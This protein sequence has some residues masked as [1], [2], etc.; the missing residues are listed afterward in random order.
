MP[1]EHRTRVLLS[2]TSCFA[3]LLLACRPLEELLNKLLAQDRAA[4]M[5]NNAS[6]YQTTRRTTE[7]VLGNTRAV[8]RHGED[9]SVLVSVL[10]VLTGSRSPA[11]AHVGRGPDAL[12]QT[13]TANLA[14]QVQSENTTGAL[15]A[16]LAT[17][18]ADQQQALFRA[19]RE[20]DEVLRKLCL[21]VCEQVQQRRD[22]TLAPEAGAQP[23]P[24]LGGNMFDEESMRV[25]L[26]WH[27]KPAQGASAALEAGVQEVLVTLG[28]YS[29]ETCVTLCVVAFELMQG[30]SSSLTALTDFIMRLL[31]DRAD[32]VSAFQTRPGV[33]EWL[34]DK[35]MEA[36][37]DESG[38]S[39]FALLQAHTR[40]S[41]SSAVFATRAADIKQSSSEPVNF[42][43]Y[44]KLAA[45]GLHSM[46]ASKLLT[47]KPPTSSTI[48]KATGGDG[49]GKTPSVVLLVRLPAFVT[50]SRIEVAVCNGAKWQANA[51][52]QKPDK[53]QSL[54]RGALVAIGDSSQNLSRCADLR[55]QAVVGKKT[56]AA[57]GY[58]WLAAAIPPSARPGRVVRIELPCTTP[59]KAGVDAHVCLAA[60]NVYGRDAEQYRSDT[61]SPQNSALGL[62]SHLCRPALAACH[63][64]LVQSVRVLSSAPQTLVTRMIEQFNTADTSDVVRPILMMLAGN[65]PGAAASIMAVL[66][67]LDAGNVSQC[68]QLAVAM[69]LELQ[70]TQDVEAL[71]AAN[72]KTLRSFVLA[73]LRGAKEDAL[74]VKVTPFLYALG[75]VRTAGTVAQDK[76]ERR[77]EL[78]V[79]L[80][81]LLALTLDSNPHDNAMRFFV[82]ARRANSN[83]ETAARRQP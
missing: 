9:A 34:V 47:G 40:S 66:L 21:L 22:A 76:G 17:C 37:D 70:G 19:P 16:L 24:E 73:Q 31:G 42:S 78:L 63:P 2:N 11:P 38:A 79:V 55:P 32:V 33:A 56:A 81:W 58:F 83:R 74:F 46:T 29:A 43:P 44:A 75:Q 3:C 71:C 69:C 65:V 59:V 72:S 57:G 20:Q 25:L 53:G 18:L 7:L 15:L 12:S 10:G 23:E 8:L 64:A 51:V 82:K 36:S 41:G 13:P 39:V 27:G 26:H 4:A 52:T 14:L 48:V 45:E 68:A 35:S 1:S 5:L 50:V 77:E 67:S 49:E 60:I 54:P 62:V 61:V 30:G 80:E 6:D 28:D